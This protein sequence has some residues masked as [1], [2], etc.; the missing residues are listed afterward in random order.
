[1]AIRV[2]KRTCSD[3]FLLQM[4]LLR[5]AF[6]LRWSDLPPEL[7]I[8]LCQA[9]YRYLCT[10]GRMQQIYRLLHADFCAH[11]GKN[12]L[13]MVDSGHFKYQN[14]RIYLAFG[15]P[16]TWESL[17]GLLLLQRACFNQRR[18]KRVDHLEKHG[19]SRRGGSRLAPDDSLEA[20]IRASAKP[21]PDRSSRPAHRISSRLPASSIGLISVDGA[22][23]TDPIL[24]EKL[25]RLRDEPFNNSP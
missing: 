7:P 8:R 6:N 16:I 20:I 11:A 4:I 18:L 2:R 5:L 15:N 13:E 19:P 9:Y 1:M 21:Q 3:R 24:H 22:C 14:G 25:K 10:S 17:T 12:L 23:L